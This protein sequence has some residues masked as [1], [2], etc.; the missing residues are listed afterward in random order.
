MPNKLYPPPPFVEL[1]FFP[2]KSQE[3]ETTYIK[4]FD[5]L[6]DNQGSTFLGV[7]DLVRRDRARS[8]PFQFGSEFEG[9]I[10]TRCT[11]A[12]LRRHLVDPD[13]RV[14][15]VF[16]TNPCKTKERII[17]TYNCTIQPTTRHAVTI[18][19]GGSF[20][21]EHK[22]NEVNLGKKIY[23]LFLSIVEA[24]RPLYA[25]ITIEEN[26]PSLSDLR[27]DPISIAFSNCYLDLKATSISRETIDRLAEAAY[28]EPAVDGIY[29][30]T[31]D[32]F[33]PKR[34]WAGVKERSQI[35]LGIA[36]LLA[37]CPCN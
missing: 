19:L 7:A 30:S 6:I 23:R 15:R 26:I 34:K 12:E 36:R 3:S 8:I 29:I 33:N 20:T 13:V 27:E 9:Q 18:W 37:N 5:H 25:A 16:L 17:L 22:G 35:T 28:R 31:T 21:E 2:N 14:C 1:G 10:Q 24:I 32:L 4:V 11:I